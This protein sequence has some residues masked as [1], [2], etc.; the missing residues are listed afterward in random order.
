MLVKYMTIGVLGTVLLSGAAMAQATPPTASSAPATGTTSSWM[1]QMKEGTWRALKFDDLDVYNNADEKIG[2]IKE[3]ILSQSGSV[4]AVV[5]GV[6]GFL[7]IGER[8]VAV[9]FNQVKFVMEPRRT[10]ATTAPLR[11]GTESSPATPPAAG[12]RPIGDRRSSDYP[13]HAVLNMTK[14]QLKAAPEFKYASAATTR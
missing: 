11:P 12:T 7:G 9:P 14:D 8:Y 13:D 4:D 2:D 5:I 6:G 1:T 10:A 3:L